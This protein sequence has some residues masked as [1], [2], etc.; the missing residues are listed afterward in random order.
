MNRIYNV[1]VVG[2]GAISSI[3]LENMINRFTNIRPIAICSA[4]M[5]SAKE[6]GERFGLEIC[7]PE[8]MFSRGDVDIIVNLTPVSEHYGI[9]KK[10][11]LS[12]KNVYTEKTV[13]ETVKQAKE[14]CSLADERGLYLGSAPDTFLGSALQSARMAL[15][16]GLIGEV[17]SF[18]ISINRSN[19]FL[20]GIF[21]FL[22]LPGA[23]A[24]RDYEVY[25]MTALVALLGPV[26]KVC[27]FVYAPYPERQNKIPGTNDYGHTIKTPNESIVTA[28]IKLENG[29]TGTIHHN[30][31]TCRT[32]NAVFAIYGR[33]AIMMLHNPNY[34]GGVIKI[35]QD[36]P[37]IIR[38]IEQD[39]IVSTLEP[40]NRFSENY[41][42][43]GV[44]EMADAISNGRK[45]RASKELAL[46]VL[47][48]LESIEISSRTGEITDVKSTC[49][50]PEPFMTLSMS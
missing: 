44:A 4:H 45:N 29:V 47:D 19:D 22:R 49:E 30:Q 2:A 37:K 9:I 35:L 11:L 46:H 42:G 38:G 17:N 41:R 28:I 1:G 50:K 10:A 39:P 14:L 31:E 25:Y 24:L 18:C 7:T 36:Q 20:T 6:K 43:L 34:F 23:G 48:V 8:E 15:N 21:P 33:K 5:E 40:G 27:A 16:E 26:S 12:G 3:Y 13:S 32:D